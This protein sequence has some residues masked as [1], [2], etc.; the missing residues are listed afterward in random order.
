M[1]LQWGGTTYAWNDGR[2]VALLTV[3]TLLLSGFIISHYWLGDIATVPPRI[4]SQRT[5]AFG[6][7][8]GIL[9]GAA[10]FLL[11]YF[12]PVWF[13]AIKGTDAL[14][15]GIDIIFLILSMTI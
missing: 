9:L 11:T 1:A 8:F 13:Q 5:I 4:V 6:S 3:F 7:L 2:V 10:F 15:S 14:H 12:L